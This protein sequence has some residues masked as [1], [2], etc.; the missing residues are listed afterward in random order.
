M[1]HEPRQNVEGARGTS[2][3]YGTVLAG[4]PRCVQDDRR[5][6]LNLDNADQCR[7]YE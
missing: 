2:E 7:V 3:T 1:R 6:M 5:N 4:E